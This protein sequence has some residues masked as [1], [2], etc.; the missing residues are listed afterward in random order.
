MSIFDD[1][2]SKEFLL[3]KGWVNLGRNHES[4]YNSYTKFGYYINCNIINREHFII[5]IRTLYGLFVYN[6]KYDIVDESDYYMIFEKIEYMIK[7]NKF[8]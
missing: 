7:H 5:K 1:K 2:I 3:G 8:E 6:Q 4:W